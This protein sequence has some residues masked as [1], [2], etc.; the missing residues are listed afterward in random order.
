MKWT[1]KV[2]RRSSSRRSIISII[3]TPRRPR[4]RLTVRGFPRRLSPGC[5]IS[6][7]CS[8]VQP[9]A[10]LFGEALYHGR[11][12]GDL[13]CMFVLCRFCDTRIYS[14][15]HFCFASRSSGGEAFCSRFYLTD[16]SKHECEKVKVKRLTSLDRSACKNYILG[17][18]TDV[19]NPSKNL[20][21][22]S[23]LYRV[24]Y[25]KQEAGNGAGVWMD[26]WEN[27]E[28]STRI[29]LKWRSEDIDEQYS[30]KG[31]HVSAFKYR[32]TLGQ[33]FVDTLVKCPATQWA[34]TVATL[35]P[36]WLTGASK[37]DGNKPYSHEVLGHPVARLQKS[38]PKLIADNAS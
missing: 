12:R 1:N 15:L 26:L 21:E 2:T 38:E 35:L 6:S 20:K 23:W 9:W 29:K 11:A 4:D 3:D 37:S 36:N 13:L 5:A 14:L 31:A 10:N 32:V 8:A 19:S 16:Y 24:C 28:A 27:K 33:S 22:L 18:R 25:S 34:V 30:L 7:S 17:R